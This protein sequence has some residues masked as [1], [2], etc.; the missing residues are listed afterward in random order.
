[1]ATYIVLLGS[2]GVGK[3]TQADILTQRTGLVHISTGDLFREHIRSKTELGI[4]AD[5]YM[6]KGE[7][8]PDDVTIA[9][10]KERISLPDCEQGAILDGF[11]RTPVQADA[12]KIMLNEIGADVD[13]VPYITVPEKILI[14]RLSG[15]WTCSES[16]HVYHTLFSPPK[17]EGVCD[18]CGAELYQRDDDTVE[19]VKKRLRIYTEKTSPLIAY[20][21]KQNKLVEIQGDQRIE[22][23]TE[24]L[25]AVLKIN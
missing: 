4:L 10:V 11:P 6:N 3:G 18:I 16:G 9:M 24:D 7:F 1:M 14:E 17:K 25:L 2:P 13:V 12:T 8:V 5:S 19:T 23:V 22:K 15:R 20:Y 21:R